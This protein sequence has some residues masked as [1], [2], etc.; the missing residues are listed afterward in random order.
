MA[1]VPKCQP[2]SKA[3]PY[4][5]KPKETST[6]DPPIKTSAQ[7]L[8]APKRQNLTL[9]DWLT[10]FAYV[11]VHPDL[12]QAHIVEFFRTR[13]QGRLEFTQASLSC[14][15]KARNELEERVHSNPTALSSKR[16]HIVTRPDVEEALLLWIGSMETKGHVVNGPMLREK[17]QRLEE[18]MN[19]P[20][21]EQLVGDGWIAPFCRAHNLKEHRHHGEAGSVDA[22]MVE[23]EQL[24]VAKLLSTFPK[25][26]R[27]NFDE[28]SLFPM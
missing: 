15:L 19:V 1:I 6:S 4:K 24:R 8:T 26:D 20:E 17:R 16:P 14:K 21:T 5:R 2:C 13:V 3:L 25:K 9:N 23:K 28:T 10:V 22:E 7:P 12:S 18:Q 27:F 11:D